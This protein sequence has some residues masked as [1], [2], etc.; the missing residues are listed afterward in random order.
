MGQKTLETQK[1]IYKK[2]MKNKNKIFISF[3][4]IILSFSIIKFAEAGSYDI[5][6]DESYDEDDFDGSSD[7]PYKK[8][9]DAIE[10]TDSKG[11]SIYVKNGTYEETIT[12][13]S[14][15][16]LTGE[17]KTKTIIK[18]PLGYTAI[19]AKGNN[20]LTNLTISGGNTGILFEAVG[21]LENCI[22]KDA[23]K[24]AVS[25]AE[26]SGKVI[27]KNSSFTGN[28]KGV[29]VQ[30][31]SSFS[32]SGNT[33]T[34]NKEEGIDIREKVN[35]SI[36]GNVI[37]NNGEG[38]IEIVVGS[39]DVSIKDN[40]IKKNGA[41]G[42]AAQFY[43]QASKKGEISISKNSITSNKAYGLVCKA[44]S[45][46]DPSPGYYDKSIELRDNKIEHN[47]K[48]AI[49]G[50]CDIVKA[51]SEEEKNANQTIESPTALIEEKTEE[52][53][54]EEEIENQEE[55]L[56]EQE[57]ERLIERE[58]LLNNLTTENDL[59]YKE[60]SKELALAID[61]AQ[62]RSKFKSFLWGASKVDLE[63]AQKIIS[64]M[65]EDK[66]LLENQLAEFKEDEIPG[67]KQ[68]A[69]LLIIDMEAKISANEKFLEEIQKEFSLFGS[70]SK[71]FKSIKF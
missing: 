12:L 37:S 49:S 4:I 16:T 51:V 42:I 28:G 13:S 50:S 34:N 27:I 60:S 61:K 58:S 64:K 54:A 26:N 24:N 30:K 5:Y 59:K 47:K 21:N 7:K 40:T 29:Y 67:G 2:A 43:S 33:F 15:I 31:G 14:G 8:I 18:S 6:V 39:S 10:E 63:N 1:L 53:E 55:L 48:K 9:E 46:G 56:A 68:D 65:Q 3:I 19:T 35:G 70:I 36:S 66:L 52:P 32:I 17:D 22:I 69:Y 45:G 25:L 44:P 11:K 62:K 20:S 38:G 57:A 71:F 41:S 23:V